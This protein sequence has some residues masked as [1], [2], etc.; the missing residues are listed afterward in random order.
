MPL[1]VSMADRRLLSTFKTQTTNQKSKKIQAT[2]V[3]KHSKGEWK[4]KL[5]QVF[6]L[7]FLNSPSIFNLCNS[8]MET[9]L[10]SPSISPFLNPK[11]SSSKTLF[12]PSLHAQ[13]QRQS[14]LF[15]TKNITCS[16]K[17]HNP[18]LLNPSLQVPRSWFAHAQQGL[19]AL[20]LSLALSFSPLL[21]TN[22]NALASEF[23][24]LNEGPPKDSYLVD[25]AGVISKVT[26]SDL[27]QLL[28]DLESRKNFHINFITVRKLTVRILAFSFWWSFVCSKLFWVLM[29]MKVLVILDIEY[30]WWCNWL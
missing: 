19:A 11:P 6:L 25:D 29:L 1:F 17:K 16:L 23:D 27:K 4:Q 14:S 28:S 22:G 15:C 2:H 8:A 10:S 7:F 3:N 24:V 20:A 21:Y 12:S 26:K 9:I 5:N 30:W 13:Q 18:Q